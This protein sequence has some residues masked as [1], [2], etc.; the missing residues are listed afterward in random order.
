MHG[1]SNINLTIGLLYIHS[2]SVFHNLLHCGVAGKS[3]KRSLGLSVSELEVIPDCIN[4]LYVKWQKLVY[5]IYRFRDDGKECLNSAG[6]NVF[7]I[8]TTVVIRSAIVWDRN[9]KVKICFVFWSWYRVSLNHL[10]PNG[11]FSGRNAPLTYRCCILYI[12]S[13]N[14]CT[15][16]FKHAAHSPFFPLKNALYFIMLPFLVPVLF[17][18]YI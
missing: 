5:L 17:T 9:W 15:E 16:F 14:I 13:T 11:H 12:F 1:N 7:L 18:F 8:L 2:S 6:N 3:V 10:T 4:I